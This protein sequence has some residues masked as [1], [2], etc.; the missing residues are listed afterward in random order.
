MLKEIALDS[1]EPGEARRAL[2]VLAQ[3][4][5]PDAQETVVQVAKSG[6]ESV[7]VA[8]VR[9]LGRFGGP[10][11]ANQLLQVYTGSNAPVK[12]QVVSSLGE[13]SERTALLRI[14]ETEKDP[15]LKASA[16]VTLGRAGGGEQLGQLYR[17]AVPAAKR[18]IIAG[19]F[20]A[21][22]DTA[23]IRIAETEKDPKLRDEAIGR[24][25]LLDTPTARA[26]LQKT[27][28]IR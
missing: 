11:M 24:L 15:Q 22:A 16:I 18:P 8:A 20:N 3:S 23:L 25:R 2:F 12:R 28:G 13:R 6:S 21:R 27:E 7:R 5:R 9:E 1:A 26:Y 19:L 4:G 10:E 17:R 14:A